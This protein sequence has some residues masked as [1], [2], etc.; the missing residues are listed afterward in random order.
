M[1][2]LPTPP[3]AQVGSDRL[4]WLGGEPVE[5]PFQERDDE[6]YADLRN[7][8]TIGDGRTNALVAR[9]GRVDWLDV[10]HLSTPPGCAPLLDAGNWGYRTLAPP[11]PLLV[12]RRYLDGTN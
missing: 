4:H 3:P 12:N 11:E 5:A 8:A 1:S 7:Y 9:D 2:T 10:P 6:G